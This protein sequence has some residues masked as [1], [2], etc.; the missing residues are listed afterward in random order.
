MTVPTPA[1]E[2]TALLPAVE[3]DQIFA[4]VQTTL[5]QLFRDNLVFGFV[6]GG[7]AKGYATRTHDI[8]LFVVLDT[9]VNTTVEEEYLRWYFDLHARYQLPPDYDYPG[10]IVELDRLERTLHLLDDWRLTRVVTSVDLKKAIIWTDMLTG[11]IAGHVG[12]GQDVLDR[13]IAERKHEPAR[14]KEQLLQQI[15]AEERP[16]WQDK[17]HTLL[18]ERFMSYPK[19]DGRH[20]ETRFDPPGPNSTSSESSEWGIAKR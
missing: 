7:V 4:E 1:P 13:L 2:D 17:N 15:P 12:T 20:L 10:E 3:R 5:P 19:H 16:A 18:M 9:P 14:W 8:D 11:G 6:C